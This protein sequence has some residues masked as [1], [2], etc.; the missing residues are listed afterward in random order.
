MA[1]VYGDNN[2]ALIHNSVSMDQFYAPERSQ[3][4][5]P[6]IGLLYSPTNF[7]GV[8]ISLQAIETVRMKIPNLKLQVFGAGKPV[9]HLPLPEGATYQQNPPQEHI[10]DIYAACD[11]W[12]CGSR[13]E[14]FHLPPL[15]AMACRCP[16]VSTC[17]GGPMDIIENGVNGYIVD[18]ED[19]DALADRLIKVLSLSSDNWRFMSDAALA[20]AKSYTWDD[21]ADLFERELF[22]S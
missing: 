18:V 7:K 17:V 14:G 15:E 12:L 11:V 9:P 10:R 6:T 20:T 8:D 4:T 13:A 1:N 16:V 2:V 19:S 5:N 22:D 21:A 3:Q